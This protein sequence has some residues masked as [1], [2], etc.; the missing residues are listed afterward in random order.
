MAKSKDDDLTQASGITTELVLELGEYHSAQRI[1]KVQT[2]LTSAAR[3]LRSLV[4]GQYSSFEGRLGAHLTHEQRELLTNAAKLL[5]SIKYNVEHAKERKAREEKAAAKLQEQRERQAKQ[6]AAKF[7]DLPV[8]TVEQQIDVLK[9]Y[10]VARSIL[11]GSMMDSDYS[12]REKMEMPAP[13]WQSSE[14]HWR[15]SH[16][17]DLIAD[18]RYSLEYHLVH[19]D[20]TPTDRLE[21]LQKCL[22]ESREAALATPSA[23]HTLKVWTDALQRAAFVK[24]LMPDKAASLGGAA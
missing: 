17:T 21:Q 15:I 22:A 23:E 4:Q 10:L 12:L 5:D 14:A 7:L 18:L 1:R 24:G 11:I 9:L 3:E 20:Q 16:V 8:E 13:K 6:M 19:R 2:G